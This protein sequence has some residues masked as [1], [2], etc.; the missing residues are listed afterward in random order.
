MYEY[1]W[2]MP[3]MTADIAVF[4]KNKEVEGG[5][6]LLL[7]K[8]GL[9]PFKGCYA[10]PGGF[11]EEGET[12]D[13]A[14]SRELMEETGVDKPDFINQ[15]RTFSEPGRDPRGWTITGTYIAMLSNPENKVHAGDDAK[16][17]K[18]FDITF[19][20]TG[21]NK[22]ELKLV[23]GDDVLTASYVSCKNGIAT[24]FEVT[25]SNGLAFDHSLIVG[26]AAYKI[27]S[28]LRHMEA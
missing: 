7:I 14:A 25:S 18:W 8:R 12:V 5:L 22:W 3:N 2:S 27:Q 21:D 16:E 28:V 6:K 15:L 19:E 13:H 10:L 24:D 23:N 20:N 9:D 26:Y 4:T 17:A 1:E 11:V